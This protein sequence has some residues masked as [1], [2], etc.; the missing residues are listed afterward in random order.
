MDTRY[1][2]L[3]EELAPL[4]SFESDIQGGDRICRI[5]GLL[6]GGVVHIEE[7][8][9]PAKGTMV[10]MSI[11]LIFAAGLLTGFIATQLWR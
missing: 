5:C 9:A 10:A 6:P 7:G 3:V 4:H 1:R 2:E 8:L 11:E